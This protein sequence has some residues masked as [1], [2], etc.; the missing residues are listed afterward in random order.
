MK[1][2]ERAAQL[3]DEINTLGEK[4]KTASVFEVKNVLTALGEKQQAFNQAV[5]EA[6]NNER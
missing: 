5:V 3:A 2:N 6:L 1:A 4:A